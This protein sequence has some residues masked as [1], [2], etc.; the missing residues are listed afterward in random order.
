MNFTLIDLANLIKLLSFL[1]LPQIKIKS[2]DLSLLIF[3]NKFKHHSLSPKTAI[4]SLFCNT[5]TPLGSVI[6]DFSAIIEF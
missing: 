1:Y 3:L 2:N 6:T 4:L 5:S